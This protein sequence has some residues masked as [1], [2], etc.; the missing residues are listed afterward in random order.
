MNAPKFD[1]NI[2]VD[3][4]VSN[5]EAFNKF[6]YTP[7][8]EA[9]Q[10]LKKRQKNEE[11]KNKIS[12]SLN[13]NLPTSLQ[14]SPRAILFR[15]I[16]TPNYETRL[17]MKTTESMGLNPLFWE[18][19]ED[20]FVSNN[21][22]KYHLGKLNFFKG[23]GKKGGLK[24]EN[25]NIIDFNSCNGKKLCRVKT[26]FDESLISFHH[27]FFE[28][29]YKK[30]PPDYF[31]DASDWFKTHGGNAANYYK[32]YLSLFVANAIEFENFMLD[33]K[34]LSFTKE[35]FLPAFCQV[36]KEF[37]VKPLIVALEPTNIETS[38]LWMCYPYSSKKFIPQLSK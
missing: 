13:N 3:K 32:N 26:I 24:L 36:I 27:R 29:T 31:F 25:K 35:L 23:V 17:F 28:K 1:M 8:N 5:R 10:E 38:E 2:D 20:K 9:M 12:R 16:A 4:L 37:G 7:L 14:N 15:Q 22:V 19:Y 33:E 6:V 34:E 21:E 11:L 18:Y 30:L